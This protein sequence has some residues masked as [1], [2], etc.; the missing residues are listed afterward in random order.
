MHG[1]AT[2]AAREKVAEILAVANDEDQIE[3]AL[4]YFKNEAVQK[5]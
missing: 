2:L 3:S 4:L 1:D 5:T